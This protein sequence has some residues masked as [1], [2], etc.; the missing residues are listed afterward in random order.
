MASR[1]TSTW[2]WGSIP[3]WYRPIWPGRPR[4]RWRNGNGARP[5]L[6]G[7]S[8]TCR[9]LVWK[10]SITWAPGSATCRFPASLRTFSWPKNMS[11]RWIDL[12]IPTGSSWTCARTAEADRNRWP[13]WSAIS[14]TSAHASTTYGIAIP[15]S[16]RSNG[17]SIRLTASAMAAKSRSSFLSVPAQCPRAKTSPTRCRHSNAPRWSARR[18]GAGRTRHGPIALATTSMPWFPTRARSVPSPEATGKAWASPRTSLRRRTRRLRWPGICCSGA[19]KAPRRWSPRAIEIA[20]ARRRP[21]GGVF[22]I[23][24]VSEAGERARFPRRFRIRIHADAGAAQRAGRTGRRNIALDESVDQPHRFQGPRDRKAVVEAL[25]R[26]DHH[27]GHT[28]ARAFQVEFRR[29]GVVV[30]DDLVAAPGGKVGGGLDQ[31]DTLAVEQ[32]TQAATARDRDHAAVGIGYALD[33]VDGRDIEFMR[34]VQRFGHVLDAEAVE[35]G[36]AVVRRSAERR[37]GDGRGGEGLADVIFQHIVVDH[38]VPRGLHVGVGALVA[39]PGT[40]L[41]LGAGDAGGIVR[42]GDPVAVR[43]CMACLVG[44]G[45]ARVEADTDAARADPRQADDIGV[46]S[47]ICND[48]LQRDAEPHRVADQ[49]DAGAREIADLVHHLFEVKGEILQRRDLPVVARLAAAAVIE[50]IDGI[51]VI[52]PI[53]G[54]EEAH[55]A[56]EGDARGVIARYEHDGLRPMAGL[57]NVDAFLWIAGR[58]AIDDDGAFANCGDGV[59]IRPRH[60]GRALRALVA[61]AAAACQAGCK[62]QWKYSDGAP[63]LQHGVLGR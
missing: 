24:D 62:N 63:G 14:S 3:G 26:I 47:G 29:G 60:A 19:C 59:G 39:L 18:P 52:E 49:R 2:R 30:V 61:V 50:G 8:A 56:V 11:R 48:H 6:C 5:C 10:R 23:R 57:A 37:I 32:R 55:H 53:D 4:R 33:H 58:G 25:V 20:P 42:N 35:Q 40:L 7:C 41:E 13:C 22:P 46:T 54:T 45:L 15:T 17:R 16:P 1:A 34:V 28:G 31:H 43:P 9:A 21:R 44:A 36:S 27:G 51:G 12:P 38:R